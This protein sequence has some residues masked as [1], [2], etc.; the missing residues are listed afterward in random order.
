MAVTMTTQTLSQAVTHTSRI[1]LW[2]KISAIFFFL[3]ALAVVDG[4]QALAR[5]DFN[6]FELI[7]GETAFISGM[8]PEG[9]TT[10][11]DL[12]IHVQGVQGL[13]VRPVASFKGFWLGGQMWRAEI[14]VP[15]F[16]IP[17]QASLTVVDLIRPTRKVSQDE[18]KGLEKNP[19]TTEIAQEELP[20]VQN[21][22]L[23]YGVTI[24]PSALDR[25]RAERSFVR[26]ISGYSSFWLAGLAAVV[27]ILAGVK[28]WF[29]FAT[30]EKLLATKGLYIVHGV[31]KPGSPSPSG[32]ETDSWQALC[33]YFGDASLN[34]GDA[35]TIFDNEARPRGEGVVREMRVD[36]FMAAFPANEPAPVY[37]WIIA[38]RAFESE[39]YIADNY[40]PNDRPDD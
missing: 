25:Q 14:Q 38:K 39:D 1:K 10:H 24:W 20:L 18:E 4:L 30:V 17:G 5:H 33:A 12:Q 23:V 32:Y 40:G 35:V 21:P 29:T 26:K 22:M 8:L 19:Q 7:P 34:V 9:V 28:G 36:S 2:G 27:G 11:E 13:T 15:E 16:V 3:A 37:S 31:K 6:S